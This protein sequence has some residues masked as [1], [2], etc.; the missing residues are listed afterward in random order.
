[1]AASTST[2][3]TALQM[4]TYMADFGTKDIE[5]RYRLQ[6]RTPTAVKPAELLMNL[7]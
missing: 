6:G 1:M 5:Y 7:L 2:L 3:V 4:Q